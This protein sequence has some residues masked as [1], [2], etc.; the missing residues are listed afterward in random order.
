MRPEQGQLIDQMSQTPPSDPKLMN[1]YH[2]AMEQWL[3]ALPE[4][5]LVQHFLY[6]PVNTTYW[7]GWPTAEN[8]YI[9]PSNWHRTSTLFINTL[10]P[11][12][13]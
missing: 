11:A 4:I 9:I 8:P 3:P 1:L 2:Q 5:P 13:Q 10:Q 6:M 12:Q 7:S